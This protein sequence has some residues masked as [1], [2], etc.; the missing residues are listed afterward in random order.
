MSKAR[1]LLIHL[2][3][4]L[5]GWGIATALSPLFPASEKDRAGNSASLPTKTDRDRIAV[6]GGR[7]ILA[8]LSARSPREQKSEPTVHSFRS[9]DEDA[10]RATEELINAPPGSVSPSDLIR[11]EVLLYHLRSVINGEHGPDLAYAFRNG[12]MDAL[13]IRDL[14][15][16]QFPDHATHTGFLRALYLELSQHDPLRA[17]VLMDS[18]P[19]EDIDDLKYHNM[20]VL[21]DTLAPRHCYQ[22]LAS[23]PP[24]ENPN[25]IQLR[26]LVVRSVASDYLDRYRSDFIHFVEQL[27]PGEDRNL[28]LRELSKVYEKS[29]PAEAAR[30]RTLTEVLHGIDVE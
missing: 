30:L 21:P 7:Q 22:L 23:I 15:A 24:S 17:E 27:P 20:M 26:S 11:E 9:I 19:A 1:P 3:L 8:R 5:A 25:E 28:T 13:E 29:N 2:A 16:A 12:R 14:L 10:G 6:K 4:G 18:L